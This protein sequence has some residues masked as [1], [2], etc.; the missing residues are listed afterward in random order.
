V[1]LTGF[2]VGHL[3]Q[4]LARGPGRDRWLTVEARPPWCRKRGAGCR[5]PW[6]LGVGGG[7]LAFGAGEGGGEAR[8]VGEGEG[9]D[10]VEAGGAGGGVDGAGADVELLEAGKFLAR[11]MWTSV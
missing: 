10:G 1:T 4:L 8:H 11:G 7:S 5:E 2:V 3:A 9:R 6:G